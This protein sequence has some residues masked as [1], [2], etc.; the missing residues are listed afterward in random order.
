[1]F[2]KGLSL[3][4]V[5]AMRKTRGAFDPERLP[6]NVW[7]TNLFGRATHNLV[8]SDEV[9]RAYASLEQELNVVADIQRSLCRWRCGDS[10]IELA[11]H[12]QTSHRAGVII[13]FFSRCRWTIRNPDRRR[14]RARHARGG[15]D[16]GNALD[17]HTH[18]EQPEPPS[19]L[20]TF[21]NRHLAA[22]YTN[23]NGGFVTAFYGIYDP[24]GRQ[25]TYGPRRAQ[26]A[27]PAPSRQRRGYFA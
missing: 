12:Y 16:G 7:M 15:A 5:V 11:A 13:R 21:I 2:D 27:P 26:P 20:L 4:M 19:K 18:H 25:L 6:E 9:K 22:R 24:V 1:M 14:G 10:N 3:N 17:R 8:L 23:D